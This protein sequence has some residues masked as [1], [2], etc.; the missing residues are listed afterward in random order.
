MKGTAIKLTECVRRESIFIEGQLRTTYDWPNYEH[1][2][3]QNDLKL[4]KE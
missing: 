1:F 3:T 2:T 4:M